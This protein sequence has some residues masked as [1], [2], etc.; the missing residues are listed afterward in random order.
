MPELRIDRT[1]RLGLD[2]ARIVAQ[3]WTQEAE[4]EWG[5]SCRA[6]P[7]ESQDRVYFER[8]GV[9]GC[10]TVS[11]SRFDLQLKLGFLLGAYS[12]QIEQKIRANLDEL[13]GPP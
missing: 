13:L 3:R 5:M 6:E 12:R 9:S 7:G 10:L 1:H 11:A 2:A 4:S 8:S